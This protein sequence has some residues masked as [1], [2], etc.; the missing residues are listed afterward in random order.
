MPINGSYP[1]KNYFEV[2]ETWTW[3]PWPGFH[4]WC[5]F[6]THCLQ[7]L[8]T[9]QSI[10]QTV[11]RNNSEKPVCLKISRAPNC[12][13]NK[14][15]RMGSPARPRPPRPSPRWISLSPK[16]CAL[17]HFAVIIS[18]ASSFACN[19]L[20]LPSFCVWQMAFLQRLVQMSL[21]LPQR[22]DPK[23]NLLLQSLDP[24]PW[25]HLVPKHIILLT[26][27]YSTL[28]DTAGSCFQLIEARAKTIS[29]HLCFQRPRYTAN[30]LS[31]LEEIDVVMCKGTAHTAPQ[32]WSQR[33]SPIYG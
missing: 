24:P 8:S 21:P 22:P 29:Y 31:V 28:L 23:Q 25:G 9:F 14:A 19:G 13:Q 15:V 30:A 20:G 12:V 10:F 26:I 6:R 3:T 27:N 2:E 32:R 33:K 11:A 18:P 7:P 5:L 17:S 1:K 4:I 16:Q